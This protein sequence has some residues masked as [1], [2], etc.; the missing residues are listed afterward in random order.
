MEDASWLMTD[1]SRS[2]AAYYAHQRQTAVP[3]EAETAVEPRR[4]VLAARMALSGLL[5]VRQMV[6]KQKPKMAEKSYITCTQKKLKK[7]QS[8]SGNFG[9]LSP[10][11]PKDPAPWDYSF[12]KLRLFL[13]FFLG[14][15]F[16]GS[17][18]WTS[19]WKVLRGKKRARS[20]YKVRVL[21][22]GIRR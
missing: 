5:L 17:K 4:S 21:T 19:L 14:L 12:R 11:G 3:R 18:S 15:K 7:T 1:D 13:G 6:P 22:G 2:L 8:F 16:F 10:W 20:G 9:S